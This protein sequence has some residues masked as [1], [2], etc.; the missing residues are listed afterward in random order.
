MKVKTF[1]SGPVETNNYIAY[2]DIKL[3]G[4]IIDAPPESFEQVSEFMKIN[5]IKAEFLILTHGHVDHIADA[6][7]YQNSGVKVIMHKDDLFWLNPPEYMMA[8]AGDSYTPCKPDII[9]QGGESYVSGNIKFEIISAPGHTGGGICVYLKSENLLF[10]GDTLFQE[11]IGRTD[12][13]G[14]SMPQLLKSIKENILTLPDETIVY[15]GHGDS[16]KIKNEKKYNPFLQ[17]IGDE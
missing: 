4:I 13:A 3:N 9:V 6:V 8:L 10:A 14:G 7:L 2:D 12:L 16:T 11:S 5:N 1:V 15:P 17:N